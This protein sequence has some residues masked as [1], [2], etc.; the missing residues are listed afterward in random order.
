LYPH[1]AIVRSPEGDM[2]S[3]TEFA[4]ILLV[5]LPGV[6]ESR[7]SANREDTMAATNTHTGNVSSAGVRHE[8]QLRMQAQVIGSGPRLVL[9]G[10]GLTGWHSWAPHAERLAATRTVARLQLLSVQYGLEDRPLPDGYSVAM[11]SA[12]LAAALDELGWNEPLDFVAWSYGAAITLDF[13]LDHP[14]RIRTLTL[15]EPP[16]A[17]V[18]PDRG[19]N[20]TDVRAIRELANDVTGDVDASHLER[21]VR[22]AAL[23]APGNEPQELPQ[24]PVWL[25]HRRSLRSA[26]APFEH[27]DDTARLRAFDRPVLLVAGTGTAPFLRSIHDALASH[28]PHARE[29]ELPAGHAPQ[30]VSMD[31]FLEL[32]ERFHAEA[33]GGTEDGAA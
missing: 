11:E 3:A 4:I 9:V 18:L 15:I 14:D 16:A 29:V 27:R 1:Q 33:D 22:A 2:T 31:R 23:V 8:Q 19:E 7:G 17:W 30:L 13:A 28:L 25:E 24:W 26:G 10:G 6:H 32:V 12:A 5:L 20:D 21:F